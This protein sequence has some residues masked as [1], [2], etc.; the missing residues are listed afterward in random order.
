MADFERKSAISRVREEALHNQLLCGAT[1]T[2]IDIA[3]GNEG[4]SGAGQ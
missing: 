2:G 4:G 3:T 1:M